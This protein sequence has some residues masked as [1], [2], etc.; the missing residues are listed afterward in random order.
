MRWMGG[1]F[2]LALVSGCATERGQ[3][4]SGI[5]PQ[6]EINRPM[7]PSPN[8]GDRPRYMYAG[9]LTGEMNFHEPQPDKPH[10]PSGDFWQ[11][12]MG[13]FGVEEEPVMLQRP[14]SGVVD[15]ATGRILVTD[16][17][18]KGVFVFDRSAGQLD[19]WE[20]ALN[21]SHFIS[22]A[23]IALGEQGEVYVADAEMGMV[24][25]MNRKG[26][27]IALIGKGELRRPVGVA[28]DA[29]TRLLYVADTYGHDIKVFDIDG[30]LLRTIGRRGDQAGEFN[31]P[32]YI[33]LSKGK[34]YVTDT[35]NTRV[36]VLDAD[37][38]KPELIIGEQGLN[39][40][41]LVRPKGVAV[42]SEGNI[43]VVESYYDHLLVYNKRGEFL[44]GIGGT[45]Q[46]IGKFYLPS[47][48]WI[49]AQDQVYVS[50][51]F[52]ARVMLFQFLG[53]DTE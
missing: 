50:D 32:T 25:R 30:R 42:D 15:E 5:P 29:A 35:V 26:K 34:L 20:M 17:G 31:Y 23:G 1:V 48:I 52:N 19:V 27:G 45:G 2:A 12:L 44:M 18:R 37:S 16:A 14:Q 49:D 8:D 6:L 41:N 4:N 36:Q 11:W 53:G 21:D 38:G 10:T 9:Q 33:A 40:G 24:V 51:M 46:D 22:P 39:V 3:F 7:W 47:G 28:F 43:Y 13:V